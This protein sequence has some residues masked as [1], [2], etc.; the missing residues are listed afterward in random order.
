MC[1]RDRT[2]AAVAAKSIKESRYHLRFS[3]SWV[4]RLGD[5]TEESHQRMQAAINHL[6][7]FSSELFRETEIE[8]EMKELGIGADL[9]L[10][11]ESFDQK[12]K[13]V[14]AEATLEIPDTPSRQT[15]G[16]TGIHTEQMGF[17]LAEFQYMQRAYPNMTW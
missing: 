1:I 9:D 13:E 6:F 4:K 10:I 16:K 15:N 5:G 11:K 14:F 2:I 8:K 7:P 12:I 3:S 17:I